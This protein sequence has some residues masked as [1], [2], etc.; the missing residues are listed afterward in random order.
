MN[1]PNPDTRIPELMSATQVGVVFNITRQA[2]IKAANQGDLPARRVGTV[3]AFLK[4]GIDEL[5]LERAKKSEDSGRAT[6]DGK[7]PGHSV[8]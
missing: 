2:V 7:T 1:E 6:S 4:S 5:A 3:W 8:L